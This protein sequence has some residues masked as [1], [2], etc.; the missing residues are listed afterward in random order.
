MA[1][2]H[3]IE[4]AAH[5]LPLPDGASSADR[6]EHSEK[7]L[8]RALNLGTTVAVVGSGCSVPFGYPNWPCMTRAILQETL[9]ALAGEAPAGS[10]P[11]AGTC[12]RAARSW[13][14]RRDNRQRIANL[15]NEI[16]GVPDEKLDA[17]A[18]MYLIG[19][20][21]QALERCGLWTRYAEYFQ[22]QF[23]T[24]TKKPPSPGLDPYH[25]LLQ[26]PITRFATTN[27]DAE[28]ERA[29]IRERSVPAEELGLRASADKWVSLGSLCRRS[30]TQR[31]DNAEKLSMFSLAV[32]PDSDNMVFHCHGRFD[33]PESIVATEA[34]Y[35]LHY[36]D[37][38][39]RAFQ[40]SIQLLLGSNPLL[41]VGY[42][43]RDEDFLR[44]LRQLG[45]LDPNRKA[46]RPIFALLDEAGPADRYQH[47]A[48]FERFGLHVIP[49]QVGPSSTT[50]EWSRELTRGLC[51]KLR[52]LRERFRRVHAD[53]LKKPAARKPKASRPPSLEREISLRLP[54]A[55]P[56]DLLAELPTGIV[57]LSGPSGAGKS[58]RIQELMQKAEQEGAFQGTFYWNSH[59]DNE[60]VTAIERAM[61][62]FDPKGRISGVLTE[63]VRQLLRQR[64]YL[65][66][67]DGCE[68]LLRPLGESGA[69]SAYSITFRRLLRAFADP[70]SQSTVLLS[71]RLWP[72]DLE[73]PEFAERVRRIDID[74]TEAPIL[75]GLEPFKG[76]PKH[77]RGSFSALCSLLRG[78]GYGLHLAARYLQ[79]RESAG[80]QRSTAL[81]QLVSELAERYPEDRLRTMV[82]Q[83]LRLIDERQD[84]PPGL[85]RRFVERLSLFV[86]PVC[87][88]T[89]DICFEQASRG[90]KEGQGR[91]SLCRELKEN[92]LLISF[93]SST[94][95][96][97]RL[98]V[99][100][101]AR[102]PLSQAKSDLA[103]EQLPSF[104]LSGFTVGQ[105]GVD[106]GSAI[107]EVRDLFEQLAS[108]AEQALA[109][110]DRDL[111][112][113]LCRNLFS[114]LRTQMEANT[115]PRWCR[116]E[117]YAR[118]G[119]RIAVLAK[120]IG[121]AWWTYCEYP[122]AHKFAENVRAPL[123][124]PELAWLYNDVA[125][126]L[127]GEGY[128]VDASSIWDQAHEMCRLIEHPHQGGS[129]HL[130]IL[131][132][133]IQAH[134]ELGLLPIARRHLEEAQR[135]AVL[136]GDDDI[137]GRLLGFSGWMTH[138]GGNLSGARELYDRC[139]RRLRS[140]NNLRARSLFLKQRADIDL[141]TGDFAK[142]DLRLRESRSLAEAGNFPELI[143]STRFSAAH[144]LARQND[145][146]AA[147]LEYEHVRREAQRI[148]SRKLEGRV[149]TALARLSLAQQ[150]AEGAHFFACRALSFAN[151]LSLGLQRTSSLL[152]LGLATLRTGPKELGIAY[153][154]Q[155]QRLGAEQQ[156]WSRSREAENKL[157]ELGV[158]AS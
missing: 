84:N 73:A 51:A 57:V 99:H 105:S 131:L 71:S 24:A 128:V 125:L 100:A 62:Y 7:M 103:P 3:D 115:A 111:A 33:D 64:R 38:S 63:R 155:V 48:L 32:R 126:A 88:A 143:A 96:E 94:S 113:Q 9:A 137:Q 72:A 95:Q 129:F 19:S 44:P 90:L 144:C 61:S 114:L 59:Y 101:S 138:L 78:N 70:D 35:Q 107:E 58:Y 76:L 106:P 116:Y 69:G 39:R 8:L 154:R 60:S 150:D 5:K 136:N 20:C 17:R 122:D 158:S 124:M 82:H 13:A 156:Y 22:V 145:F 151:E 110:G 26:L 77:S 1:P 119:I 11:G 65:L 12:P 80:T 91:G 53:W 117:E 140:E 55:P 92:L 98:V 29:L 127:S 74:R 2:H 149:L 81:K 66:I 121:P 45:V 46:S 27:Y 108:Q 132:N 4:F 141:A 23:S 56:G 142:A 148:G 89:L 41:F 104:G 16:A 14:D 153:L 50:E 30:F 147:R 6:R 152:V 28:I 25:Q 75:F 102:R 134:V 118:F 43:L 139:L 109:G 85:A 67:L 37:S 40:E 68:R 86:S 93:R 120:R 36:L 18:L 10:E 52:Y 97:E 87:D 157:Q 79:L 34:D 49:F 54:V 130:E 15:E 135:I 47:E 83:L 146:V 21:K 42:S 31:P 133:L 123:Y 112:G